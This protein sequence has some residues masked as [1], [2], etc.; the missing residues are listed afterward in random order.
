[1][2][3]SS[4]ERWAVLAAVCLAAAAWAGAPTAEQKARAEFQKGQT[5]Y[6][7]A[8]FK[9]ALG[10]FTEAYR[11]KPLTGFLFNIGQCQ[12]Q[13]GAY[14]EA[15]FFFRRY[16]ESNPANAGVV[17]DLLAEVE[18]ALKEQERARSEAMESARERELLQLRVQSM[19]L[20]LQSAQMRVKELEAQIK[21]ARLRKE[22]ATPEQRAALESARQQL[23]A[24]QDGGLV[25]PPDAGTPSDAG[26]PE[27]P[28][29]GIL[30]APDGGILGAP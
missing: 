17:K 28:D 12:R 21:L 6:D 27:A 13:L 26:I 18:G 19:Q 30:D 3:R 20:E 1:M 7:L 8:Q 22:P 25:D 10:H 15:A 11:L 24:I 29:G 16:L 14:K 9:E 23:S 2:I 4:S 5:A